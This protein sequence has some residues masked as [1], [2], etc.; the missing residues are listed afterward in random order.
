[1]LVVALNED[2]D[3]SE[4]DSNDILESESHLRHASSVIKGMHVEEPSDND[5]EETVINES[6]S[7]NWAQSAFDEAQDIAGRSINGSTVN[8]FYNMAA[9]HNI[10]KLIGY[11]PLWSGIMESHLRSHCNAD[12]RIATSSSVEAEF[13]GLKS[14]IFKGRIPMKVD[15]FIIQHVDY[16]DGR[17]LLSSEKIFPDA[18]KNGDPPSFLENTVGKKRKFEDISEIK[19]KESDSHE[20]LD[21]LDSKEASYINC[22][23]VECDPKDTT[24]NNDR[25]TSMIN[26]TEHNTIIDVGNHSR[27]SFNEIENWRG[28]MIDDKKQ[29]F[30]DQKTYNLYG[31][32]P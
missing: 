21:L 23:E 7:G 27:D 24:F 29:C 16:L 4:K 12:T 17:I 8:A 9:A 3:V 14:R 10:R 26:S 2:I 31:F 20:C 18:L 11:L 13:C 28:K 30:A 1:M 19:I 5:D 32:L 15:K 6:D 22:T 25:N